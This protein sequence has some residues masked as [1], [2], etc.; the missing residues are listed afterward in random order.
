[1]AS[2]FTFGGDQR[3]HRLRHYTFAHH[4]TLTHHALRIASFADWAK[5]HPH[6]LDDFVPPLSLSPD[7]AVPTG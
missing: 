6:A 5:G 7:D 1:M 2:P 3:Y 4:T